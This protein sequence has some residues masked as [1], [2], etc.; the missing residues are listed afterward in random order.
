MTTQVS[1]TRTETSSKSKGVKMQSVGLVAVAAVL[2]IISFFVRPIL[3]TP[4][5]PAPPAS[6]L[7]AFIFLDVWDAVAFG[8]GVAL[9]LYLALNFSKWPK[10]IRTPLL[11]IFLIA[12]WFSIPNWIHDGLH[13]AGAAPPNFQLLAI[14]EYAFH[15][16]WLIMAG[17]LAIVAIKLARTYPMTTR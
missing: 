17:A 11:V 14:V 4:L 6:L 9:L 7:P 2:A 15:F 1:E 5:P 12:A 10:A 16:P 13:E 3:L 8:I